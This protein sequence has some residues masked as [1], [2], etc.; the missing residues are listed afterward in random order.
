TPHV[1]M[2]LGLEAT[3]TILEMYLSISP[4]HKTMS[5]YHMRVYSSPS[6]KIVPLYPPELIIQNEDTYSLKEYEKDF[7]KIGK[8]LEMS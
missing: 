1:L 3:T 6:F 5:D 8:F 4:S 2:P 7:H